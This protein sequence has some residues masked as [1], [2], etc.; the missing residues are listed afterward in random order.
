MNDENYPIHFQF[1]L[2]KDYPLKVPPMYKIGIPWLKQLKKSLKKKKETPQD[3]LKRAQSE[4]EAIWLKKKP[5]CVIYDWMQWLEE[6]WFPELFEKCKKKTDEKATNE[7]AD[8]KD[9][10]EEEGDD[11]AVVGDTKLHTKLCFSNARHIRLANGIE[12][13]CGLPLTDR[14][15][16][17]QA[18][19][20]RVQTVDQVDDVVNQ[21]KQDNKIARA[22]HNIMAYRIAPNSSVDKTAHAIEGRDDDGEHSGGDKMLAVLRAMNALNVVV[23]VSRWYGGIH[24][25]PDRFRH[26]GNLTRQ[27]VEE[28]T[29]STGE[30]SA[31]ASNKLSK[32][33]T[34]NIEV[35]KSIV[36][37]LLSDDDPSNADDWL[38]K[39]EVEVCNTSKN[40]ELTLQKMTL[41]Q[42]QKVFK[43]VSWVESISFAGTPVWHVRSLCTSYQLLKDLCKAK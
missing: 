21:L 35:G 33:P 14:K 1:T 7:T 30:K 36:R 13:T 43:K 22:T 16:T 18:F 6:A 24:L 29:N 17:F 2:S 19:F 11:K 41:K 42:V 26:I 32:P 5:D 40:S 37:S 12:V 4:L 15:S 38:T 20:S 28:N 9:K 25:G 34:K 10:I 39:F 23:V 3:L 8:Q 31:H 27:I